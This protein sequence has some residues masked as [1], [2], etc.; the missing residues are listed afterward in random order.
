MAGVIQRG[1]PG[2]CLPPYLS[3]P[4]HALHTPDSLDNPA[5]SLAHHP[6]PAQPSPAFGFLHSPCVLLLE[7]T[8]LFPLVT[9]CQLRYLPR[10]PTSPPHR[11][12]LLLV[13]ASPATILS[14]IKARHQSINTRSL[15]PFI[16]AVSIWSST[17]SYPDVADVCVAAFAE[18]P[19]TLHTTCPQVSWFLFLVA[20]TPYIASTPPSHPKSSALSI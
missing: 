7:V 5:K 20:V 1:P 17:R 16:C 19:D 3:V 14:F 11:G 8:C 10:L 6:S 9:S 2:S 4:T 12:Y 18:L 15:R 13:T